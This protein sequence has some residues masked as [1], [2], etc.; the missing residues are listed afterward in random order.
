MIEAITRIFSRC[1]ST[2]SVIPPTELFNEGWMLR[3][4]LDWFDRNREIRHRLSF[5][6]EAEWYSEA[7]LTPRFLPQSRADSRS[8]SFTHADGVVGHFSVNS[9]VRG[10]ALIL[11]NAKQFIVTEAKIG[12]SL[13]AGTKN[14][15]TYDQAARTVSCIAHMIGDAGTDP[16][17]IAALAFYVIAPEAQIRLGVFA[18]LVTKDSIEAKVRKRVASY[19]GMHDNW[20]HTVFMPTLAHIQLGILSWE[21]ILLALPE[22]S[23]TEIM[24]SFY[25]QCLKFNLPRMQMAVG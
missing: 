23:E 9:G 15:P 13:S 25:A 24:R 10:D 22:T 8:E 19:E 20:L 3:L 12:S 5:A 21:S 17:A 18:S 14:A 11:P 6:P 7:L 1:G 2:D 4:V 16:S